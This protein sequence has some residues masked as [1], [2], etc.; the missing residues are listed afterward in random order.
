MEETL[1]QLGER[2]REARAASGLTLRQLAAR[3]GLSPAMLCLIEN[4]QAN[5]TVQSLAVLAG[6][7]DCPVGSL[8]A[9]AEARRSAPAGPP[10][11]M[12]LPA[13]LRTCTELE[14]GV[15]VSP[16]TPG[17]ATGLGIA[18]VT[19]PPGSSSGGKPFRHAGREWGLVLEGELTVEVGGERLVLRPGD[20]IVFDSRL[21][22]RFANAGAVPMRAVWANFHPPA[23]G[24]TPPSEPIRP[25]R[26]RK[27]PAR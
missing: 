18:E 7:L 9:P 26:R 11:R 8:L 20:S 6:A 21:P 12:V 4:G 19:Y 10:C 23:D 22:H 14:G 24:A 1:R 3:A 5:P 27:T 16:L 15:R 25:R 13:A 17:P 2:V